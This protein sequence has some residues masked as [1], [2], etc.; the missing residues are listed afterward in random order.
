MVLIYKQ[1]TTTEIADKLFLSSKT[2]EGHRNR[3]LQKTNARN[4][5]GLVVFAFKNQLVTTD[6]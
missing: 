4:T 3:L 2:V 5:A 1:H 6:I